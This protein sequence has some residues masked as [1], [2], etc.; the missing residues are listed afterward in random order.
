M[1]ISILLRRPAWEGLDEPGAASFDHP[2]PAETT[3]WL[4]ECALPLFSE[5]DW[6]IVGALRPTQADRTGHYA[7]EGPCGRVVV[8]VKT[9]SGGKHINVAGQIGVFLTEAEVP[10]AELLPSRNGDFEQLIGGLAVTVTR[11]RAGR[12]TNFD[13]AD[14]EALGRTLGLVHR[15]LGSFPR[16]DDVKRD[17]ALVVGELNDVREKILSGSLAGVPDVW[18]ASLSISARRYDRS[19]GGGTAQCGHGDVTPGNVLFDDSGDAILADFEVSAFTYRPPVFDLASAVLRFCLSAPDRDHG[20]RDNLITA[21]GEASG[22]RIEAATLDAAMINIVD[23]NI[24]VLAAASIAGAP[25]A[26]A[27]WDKFQRLGDI[28]AN[29]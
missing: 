25:P 11:Y 22:V 1:S 23:H 27:E 15:A 5:G 8:H 2:V 14:A 20:R 17:T 3:T 18:R 29:P 6:R 26:P 16:R 13:P 21:Y 12:H 10:V 19:F 7:V 9:V 4:R 28:A 24:L